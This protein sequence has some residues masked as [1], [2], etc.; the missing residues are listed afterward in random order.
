MT[1]EDVIRA[2]IDAWLRATK[3]G[4]AEALSS[5]LDDDVLFVV[6]GRAP[7]GKKEFFAGGTMAPLRFESK[8]EIA[9]VVVHGD[10]A[11]TRIHL[12][13]QIEFSRDSGTM[14]LAGP[15]MSV[16]RKTPAGRWS[17]WRDSNMVAP[18]G[19]PDAGAG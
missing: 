8:V 3:E 9:E 5:L 12:E 16:W 17:I 2:N 7:F 18:A 10:W 4:N 13:L 14:S 6:P 19:A 15:T 11:L 1:D